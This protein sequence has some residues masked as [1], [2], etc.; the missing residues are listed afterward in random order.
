MR[1]L[2]VPRTAFIVPYRV[3]GGVVDILAVIRASR[4]WPDAFD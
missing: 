1:E 4:Q 3:R 2:I